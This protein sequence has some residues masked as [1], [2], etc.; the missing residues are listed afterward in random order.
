MIPLYLF[1]ISMVHELAGRFLLFLLEDIRM[2]AKNFSI[3]RVCCVRQ[4]KWLVLEWC[5]GFLIAASVYWD[6]EYKIGFVEGTTSS[7][8]KFRRKVASFNAELIA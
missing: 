8:H 1:A 3:D 5:T 6:S 2:E 4:S 7:S